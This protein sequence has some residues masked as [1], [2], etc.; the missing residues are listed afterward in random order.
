MIVDATRPGL[1]L[2]K[3]ANRPFAQRTQILDM[4]ISALSAFD[5]EL[6]MPSMRDVGRCERSLQDL[7]LMW[8]LIES[9]AKM[10][11]ST[12]STGPFSFPDATT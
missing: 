12:I 10:T 9:S 5:L 6:F 1:G 3:S 11:I 2:A 4:E 7:N 8:R